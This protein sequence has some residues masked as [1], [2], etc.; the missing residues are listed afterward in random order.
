MRG[1]VRQG[2]VLLIPVDRVPEGVERQAERG[3]L[4]VAKGEATGHHHSF[5]A[6]SGVALIEA[7]DGLY[8]SAPWS[9][10]PF[11]HQEHTAITI[12]GPYRSV[13][14]REYNDAEE[15]RRVQD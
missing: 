12:T 2:D 10:V 14:Q 1:M 11:E 3:R 5:A 8:V 4:I 15:F 13:V 9:G 7:P 6:D